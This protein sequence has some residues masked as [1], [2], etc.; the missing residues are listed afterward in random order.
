MA[1]T[2]VGYAQVREAAREVL[3]GGERCRSLQIGETHITLSKARLLEPPEPPPE[4]YPSV[5]LPPANDYSTWL[6]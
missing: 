6:K 3:Q 1:Y 5:D 4:P 2:D